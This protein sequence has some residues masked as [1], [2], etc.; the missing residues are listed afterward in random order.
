MSETSSSEQIQAKRSLEQY[1]RGTRLMIIELR[2]YNE[3]G[4]YL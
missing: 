2:R 3:I 1:S 4:N